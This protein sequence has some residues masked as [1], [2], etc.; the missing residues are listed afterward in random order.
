MMSDSLLSDDLTCFVLVVKPLNFGTKVMKL[1]Q[2]CKG[3]WK[4]VIFFRIYLLSS[5]FLCTFAVDISLLNGEL[6]LLYLRN[7][8]DEKTETT[9]SPPVAGNLFIS[10]GSA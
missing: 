2:N 5:D 7:Q 8:D 9:L 1:F 4:K 6:L 3:K 10:A